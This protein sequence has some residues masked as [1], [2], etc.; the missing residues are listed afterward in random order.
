M[1]DGKTFDLQISRELGAI[2]SRL[3]GIE[4]TLI[5]I[6]QNGEAKWDKIDE[7]RDEIAKNKSAIK[8]I[9]GI[10]TGSIGTLGLL[11]K[12]LR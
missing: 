7:S 1:P 5:K 3:T 4:K 12:F 8:W 11:M 9:I 6:E 10:G 2:D